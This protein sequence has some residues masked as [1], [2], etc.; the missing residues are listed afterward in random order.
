M[1]SV[2]YRN[3]TDF[4]YPEELKTSA[5]WKSLMKSVDLLLDNASYS[6]RRPSELGYKTYYVFRPNDMHGFCDMAKMMIISGGEG[7]VFCSTL[8]GPVR[9]G[10]TESI[11]EKNKVVNDGEQDD[12]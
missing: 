9:W 8:Q 5:A 6:A 12:V 4:R 1:S 2:S 11:A 3:V 7:H 10:Q